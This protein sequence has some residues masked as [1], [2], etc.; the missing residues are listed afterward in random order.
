[1]Y[2][3]TKYC[4]CLAVLLSLLPLAVAHADGPPPPTP[5]SVT[6]GSPE[7]IAPNVVDLVLSLLHLA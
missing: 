5:S 4:L 1:M 2:R 6:G 7:P 3:I